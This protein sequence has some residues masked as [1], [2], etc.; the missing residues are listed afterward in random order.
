MEVGAAQG[1]CT[2]DLLQNWRALGASSLLPHPTWLQGTAP[3][4]ETPLGAKDFGPVPDISLSTLKARVF[5]RLLNARG[6]S[7]NSFK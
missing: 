3:K 4:K 5:N 1:I 7:L 6:T 2:A